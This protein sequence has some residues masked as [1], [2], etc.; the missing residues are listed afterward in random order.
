MSN[1]L[2]T[3]DELVALA[4]RAGISGR[5]A[6][7]V[8]SRYPFRVTPYYLALAD[9]SDPGDPLARQFLPAADEIAGDDPFPADPFGETRPGVP[10]GVVQRFSD[11]ALV[12]VTTCCAVRCRHCTRKNLIGPGRDRQAA[13]REEAVAFVRSRPEI[14]EVILS[15]GDPLVLPDAELAAWLEAMRDIAHVEV[16]RVG[17]RVPV[18]MPMRV[19][20]SLCDLLAESRPLWVNTQFNHSRELTDEAMAA[21]DRLL[22][23][24]IPV[25]NQSV[26]LRGVNDTAEEVAALC[27]GL[28]RHMVRPY[29]MF[30]CDPVCG[31]GGFRT[32]LDTACRIASEV[33]AGL[34]GLAV[35]RFVA[36]VPG[37]PYKTPVEQVRHQVALRGPMN[38]EESV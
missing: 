29:Y 17:T 25:S 30:L 32:D 12:M 21:C 6:P 14:R 24:G 26:L 2:R 27:R 11:R 20:D 36:D 38:K 8:C 35:P 22:R 15:G 23:R 16:L 33:R 1:S 4:A 28:Q 9:L 34:G 19:T 3:S 37:V 7:D 13:D 10:R 31:V 5:V 18:V